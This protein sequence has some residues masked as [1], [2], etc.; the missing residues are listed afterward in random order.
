MEHFLYSLCIFP[1]SEIIELAFTVLF[2]VLR[3]YGISIIG[4]SLA[5]TLCTLPIYMVA[6]NWQE[7]E[8]LKV[9]QM[10]PMVKKIKSSF[11]GDE[12]FMLLSAYYR[13]VGYK[14]IYALRSSFSILIQI[15]FFLAAYRF[16]SRLQALK[17][18]SF[19]FLKDLGQPDSLLSF[20]GM[21]FN[22]LPIIMT[23]VNCIS[24]AV[25]S[26]G[27][28]LREKVQIY[29]LAA[30]FLVVLYDSPSGLLLYWTMNNILSLVKNLFYKMKH[31]LR[32]LYGCFCGVSLSVSYF[33]WSA[34]RGMKTTR[35]ALYA[36]TLLVFFIPVE[37][38]LVRWYYR[39]CLSWMEKD[40]TR[41]KLFFLSALAIT[42]LVGLL[43]PLNLIS[44]SPTEFSFLSPY[45][46]PLSLVSITFW[47]A[48]GCFFLWPV[49]LYFLFPDKVK[50]FFT[51]AGIMAV[52]AVL[53]DA[54][55]FPGRYG[56]LSKSLQF[57][58]LP[59]VSVGKHMAALDLLSL[60]IVFT[61]ISFLSA[62]KRI[63][64]AEKLLVVL[65]MAL[66]A[67]IV[68]Q[69]A[70]IDKAYKKYIPQHEEL[71]KYKEET[72]DSF[73]P[74]FHFSRQGK[75]V[76]V[77]M[78]DRGI[79][80]FVGDIFKEDPELYDKFSGFTYYPNTISFGC[81][82]IFGTP[83]IYG[84]YEY[85][86]LPMQQR[87]GES[88]K[89]K[90]NEALRVMPKMFSDAGYPVVTVDA[91][92]TDY[93]WDFTDAPFDGMKGVEALSIKRA[94]VD[95]W[96]KNCFHG[97]FMDY[98]TIME[99]NLLRYAVFE[100]SPLFLHAFL[101][102]KGTWLNTL[103]PRIKKGLLTNEFIMQYSA[104][105]ALPFITEVTDT[106]HGGFNCYDDE[107]AHEETILQTPG[108]VPSLEVHNTLDTPYKDDSEYHVNAAS[109]RLLGAWFDYLKQQGVYD[110][111]RIIIVSDHG[112]N[113]PDFYPD[114]I[115]LPSAAKRLSALRAL[116]WV[117]DFNAKG[118]FQT[119]TCFMT[120]A[121]VPYLATEDLLPQVNPYS[122]KPL[123][124]SRQR[125]NKATV[126]TSGA[127]DAS[128]NGKYKFS[129]KDDQWLTVH[130]DIFDPACWSKGMQ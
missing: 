79:S 22:L 97:S 36:L 64:H 56:T 10:S 41:N 77:I 107:L 114:N 118:E 52:Y 20:R 108:Y 74:V 128:L 59:S 29:G 16:L 127:W 65:V 11:H 67:V 96:N 8:R 124:T 106:N 58:V 3:I 98:A 31:P 50:S 54:Y 102:D 88:L 34:A 90:H 46:S 75:N 19:W 103:N 119:D 33:V 30:V 73:K 80:G 83:G 62:T 18:E 45:K 100:A 76:L 12:R 63:H 94:Y 42:S 126:T 122:G 78:L 7:K 82:T 13:E 91:P 115:P 35:M 49:C 112:E 95:W 66:I 9:I 28:Q 15:P 89:D 51:L 5:V 101:Y 6:E 60:V 99:C 130:D 48:A 4:L 110:N 92:F 32:V 81:H 123:E 69:M 121:D 117:K 2:R 25:Y 57:A 129:I 87:E 47:E 61:L 53:L 38:R 116:L 14:P 68:I 40:P 113:L 85:T 120:N 17:G 93:L 111:T 84:G 55:V 44:T 26:H 1:I 37:Y 125:E 39:R 43:I 27:H 71:S 104:N 86:P 21:A 109:Y 105:T 72:P 23:A 24:G 70:R